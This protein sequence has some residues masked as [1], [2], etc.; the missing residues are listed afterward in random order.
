MLPPLQ[1]P[2]DTPVTLGGLH[3]WLHQEQ[4]VTEARMR[5]TVGRLVTEQ[6]SEFQALRISLVGLVDKMTEMSSVFDQRTT[7]AQ[8]QIS[9][10][11]VAV[12]GELQA[13]DETLR[14][15]LDSS[16]VA[17]NEK[18]DLLTAQLV[19]RIATSEADIARNLDSA[20]G[21]L[22]EIAA[23]SVQETNRKSV[24]L[25]EQMKFQIERDGH[26]PSEGGKG[27]FSAGP[28]ERNIYDVR[29]YKIAD[30]EKGASTAS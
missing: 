30:L 7:A 23:S 17:H 2:A 26:G 20:V 25:Y 19:E 4:Y 18:F 3:E 10:R 5:E 12:M 1:H 6:V 28:R 27:C 16:S 13:R 11:Q 24:E 29:D 14:N 15:F 22:N 8:T 9:D 21:R